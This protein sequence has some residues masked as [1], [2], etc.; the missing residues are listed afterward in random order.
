VSDSSITAS[1]DFRAEMREEMRQLRHDVK[2]V[3]QV[4]VNWVRVEEKQ[5]SDRTRLENLEARVQ[6]HATKID[7]NTVKL[8]TWVQRGVGLYIGLTAAAG[9]FGFY[10]K[11]L[12]N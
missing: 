7:A 1:Q 2:S 11:F 10:V 5:I 12:Q 8:N 3:Q 9:A 6:S 4:L